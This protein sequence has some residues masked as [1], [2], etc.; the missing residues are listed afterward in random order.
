M[1]RAAFEGSPTSL[2]GVSHEDEID[3]WRRRRED[4]DGGVAQAVVEKRSELVVLDLAKGD[5]SRCPCAA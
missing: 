4:A 3:W 1:A 2:G 5:G